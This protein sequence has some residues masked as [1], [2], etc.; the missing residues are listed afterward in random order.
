[1]QLSGLLPRQVHELEASKHALKLT[2][3]VESSVSLAYTPVEHSDYL[4]RRYRF[5]CK[6]CD[7]ATLLKHYCA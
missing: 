4:T 5:M 7:S 3:N 2:D 6:V 1:M